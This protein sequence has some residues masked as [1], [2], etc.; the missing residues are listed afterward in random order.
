M[1]FCCRRVETIVTAIREIVT[2]RISD[3]GKSLAMECL[4]SE[5]VK[6]S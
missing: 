5:T 1:L 4:R 2:P 6:F 3:S